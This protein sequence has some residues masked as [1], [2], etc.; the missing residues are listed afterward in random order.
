MLGDDPLF[1]PDCMKICYKSMALNRIYMKPMNI[2]M[3][4]WGGH[5]QDQ[6]PVQPRLLETPMKSMSF[7]IMN[8]ELTVFNM[9]I[10]RTGYG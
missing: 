6:L 4:G 10:W 5:A 9:W 3:E 1:S 8:M 7:H 2:D